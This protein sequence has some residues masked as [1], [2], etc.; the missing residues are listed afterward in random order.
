MASRWPDR[1]LPI[2]P[3]RRTIFYAEQAALSQEKRGPLVGM[4]DA[5]PGSDS[6]YSTRSYL[7]AIHALHAKALL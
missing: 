2:K 3:A 1:P 4:C 7:H 6:S 5:E